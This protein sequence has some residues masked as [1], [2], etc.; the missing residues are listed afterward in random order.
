MR[1]HCPKHHFACNYRY[2]EI[3]A[4]LQ[5]ALPEP[6]MTAEFDA[7]INATVVAPISSKE[8]AIRH[9]FSVLGTLT[10]QEIALVVRLCANS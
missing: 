10:A 1:N 4:T 7:E 6:T 5:K 2:R 3:I 9:F 8:Q